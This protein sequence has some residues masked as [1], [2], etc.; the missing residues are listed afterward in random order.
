M[1]IMEGKRKMS[2]Q[3]RDYYGSD[4]EKITRTIN[5]KPVEVRWNWNTFQTTKGF[6]VDDNLL[7]WVIGQETAIQECSL[8]L[9]EWARKIKYLHG[10]EWYQTWK[11]PN[12]TKSTAK[13]VISPGPY[14]LLLGDPGTGK[15]LLGKALSA[16][17]TQMYKEMNLKLSDVLCWKNPMLPS[18]PK[19]SIHDAGEGKK[20]LQKEN[21][22][23]L[24]RKFLSKLGMKAI[25]IS[26]I[27]LGVVLLTI[28]FYVMYQAWQAWNTNAV[29]SGTSLQQM[30]NG[31]FMDFMINRLV[32]LVP[33]TIVPGG[34]LIFFGVMIGWLSKALGGTG[35]KGIGG[36]KQSDCP[37]LIVDNSAE[38]A[39]FVDATGHRSS[40]LFGSIA[41]D[42]YQCYDEVTRVLTL[43]GLKYWYEVKS[44]DKVF[45]LNPETR[46]LEILDYTELV[47]Y[48]YNGE[49]LGIKGQRIDLLVTPNHQ[50]F[51]AWRPHS[52]LYS[53]E[54]SELAKLRSRRYLPTS[55]SKW[56]SKKYPLSNVLVQL[57]GWY[58]IEG[59]PRKDRKY[60]YITQHKYSN[61]VKKLLDQS[62]LRYYTQP[63]EKTGVRFVI[64]DE[65]FYHYCIDCGV[66]SKNKRIPR[67]LLDLPRE[68]LRTLFATMIMGNGS[69][70]RVYHTASYHLALDVVELCLKIGKKP[71]LGH[72]REYYWVSTSTSNTSLKPEHWYRKQYHGKVWCLHLPRNHNYLVERNGKFVFCGNTGGLG[73]YSLDTYAITREGI[74]SYNELKKGDIV[75]AFDKENETIEEKKVLDVCVYNYGELMHHFVS[76][77]VDLLVTPNHKTFLN[78]SQ[79]GKPDWKVLE[80]KDIDYFQFKLPVRARWEGKVSKDL[81]DLIPPSTFIKHNTNLLPKLSLA[82]LCE[83]IGWFVAEGYLIRRRKYACLT[84]FK[85]RTELLKLL[86]RMHLKYTDYNNGEEILVPYNQLY[87]FFKRYC[88]SGTGK[89]RKRFPPHI[90]DYPSDLLYHLF[91]GLMNGNGDGDK[92]YEFTT[93]IREIRDSF[94]VLIAKLGW[95]CTI[96]ER[97]R[98]PRF[99]KSLNRIIGQTKPSYQILV[100]KNC[101]GYIE[102]GVNTEIIAN[103]TG[104]VWCPVI[105]DL[106]NLLVIRNGKLCYSGN[107][108]EHQRVSAG[109]VHVASL[110]I[111]FIDEIKN[112]DPE[113]AVTLL[114]VLEDGQLPITMRGR[115]NGGDTSAMAVSTEPVP[116]INFLIAAGNFD[117]I[118]LIHPALMDRIYGYG[119]VVRMNNDMPNTVENRRKYV[120]FIA[121]E[122]KRFNLIPF[123]REACI[124]VTEEGRRRSGKNDALSVRFRGIITIVKTAATLAMDENCD[125]VEAKHVKEAISQHCKTIQRQ[126]LESQMAER[127]KILEIDPKGAKHGQIYGLAVVSEQQSQEMT[128]NVLNIKASMTKIEKR[129]KKERNGSLTLTGGVNEKSM[130]ADSAAK[131]RN[132]ILQKYGIDIAQD[133]IT[134]IDYSQSYGVDGPSA[135]VTMTILLCS[136]IEGKA[137]RQDVAVT[138][139][140]N[141]SVDGKINITAVGGVHEKIKAAE[142]WGFK[143]VIIPK[144]N[145]EHS[146]VPRDYSLEV[147]PAETLEEY[148]QNCFETKEQP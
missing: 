66:G 34:S 32:G 70:G 55:A 16:K 74:K 23:E 52:K 22:K 4:E 93:S 101:Q 148:L 19:T 43:D 137:I 13:S 102:K 109:D 15:S 77:E 87:E 91:K 126:L 85:R 120:Q 140:I 47:N 76:K 130:M 64:E 135:G 10:T 68:N 24:K 117:S 89:G 44:T 110:G 132:V 26:L 96:T 113:E 111:L 7:N 20:I 131:V 142:A 33:I 11:D 2:E 139:E 45:S 25:Q 104:K 84:Q 80:A 21:R 67:E 92:E 134:H 41:W 36:A 114:T 69:N 118:G 61:I 48:D 124:E 94:I 9:N 17:I 29:T 145:Y 5:G 146:I 65:Q 38:Q 1:K 99:I 46:E 88:L 3:Y 95:H 105:E 60:I 86:E 6:P 40:Q 129:G 31:N 8:C 49:L 37:K 56:F 82:D 144:K 90:L 125:V 63:H 133:Y 147:V 81:R 53:R 50:M 71:T 27:L 73:C 107:T 112:L 28:G 35:Q 115:A 30:Y 103:N 79:T 128:G 98:E 136:L 97:R 54:A 83:L 143:K 14:L 106:H 51:T 123:S 127:A 121:Q 116:T 12:K 18:Q 78:P 59:H 141:L 57:L 62:G 138:G 119:K 42:P 100:Q 108:P 122:V 39:P 72:S 58:I 75:F